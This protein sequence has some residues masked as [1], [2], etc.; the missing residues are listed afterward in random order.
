MNWLEE[1]K[2]F[3]SEIIDLENNILA[4]VNR[5]MEMQRSLSELRDEADRAMTDLIQIIDTSGNPACRTCAAY[6]FLAEKRGH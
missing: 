3:Q 1:V 5:I 6:K 2:H 4:S